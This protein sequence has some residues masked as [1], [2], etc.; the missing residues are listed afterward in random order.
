MTLKRTRVRKVSSKQREKNKLKTEDSQRMYEWFREI[1]DER[2]DEEGNCYC[3][4][5][6]RAMHGSVY[7]SNT[8][9]YDHVLEKES[10]PQYK[11]VKRNIVIIHPEIHNQKGMNIDKTPKIKKYREFLLSLHYENKL[12]D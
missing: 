3:F 8:C 10:W 1:W 4:E 6:G 7:R 12:E 2:E 9:V 5:T 11:M